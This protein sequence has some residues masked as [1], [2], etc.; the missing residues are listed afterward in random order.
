MLKKIITLTALATLATLATPTKADAWGAAR[1]GA[2]RVGPRGGVYGAS[3]TVVAGPRG[4]AVGGRAGGVGYGGA[5]RA[6][7]GG[8]RGYGGGYRAGYGGGAYGYRYGYI[9]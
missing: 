1:V 9:R 6:G 7:Y 5:Y 8:Y 2:V 3:R 4:I